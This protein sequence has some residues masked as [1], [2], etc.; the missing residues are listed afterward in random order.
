MTDKG[1]AAD[2][3]AVFEYDHADRNVLFSH[4]SEDE[5][6]DTS[7]PEMIVVDDD[8]EPVRV[9][10]PQLS[11]GMPGKL[12]SFLDS[13]REESVRIGTEKVQKEV[14][15]SKRMNAPSSS[16]SSVKMTAECSTGTRTKRYHGL[17]DKDSQILKRTEA[18]RQRVI[19]GESGGASRGQIRSSKDDGARPSGSATWKTSSFMPDAPAS[20]PNQPVTVT[21]DDQG[22]DSSDKNGNAKRHPNIYDKIKERLQKK[23]IKKQP[24]VKVMGNVREV[25]LPVNFS[26]EEYIEQIVSSSYR[27]QDLVQFDGKYVISITHHHSAAENGPKHHQQRTYSK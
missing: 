17:I 25:L 9:T 18:I 27:S 2:N 19:W 15:V 23:L 5:D 21:L 1:N 12:Q 6:G 3:N 13:C 22:E 16:S 7:S 20:D 26:A 8:H 24:V 11:Q 10:P 4:F 14:E